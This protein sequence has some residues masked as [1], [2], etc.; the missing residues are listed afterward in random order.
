MIMARFNAVF[1]STPVLERTYKRSSIRKWNAGVRR[2][3]FCINISAVYVVVQPKRGL[4]TCIVFV[5][6]RA[7]YE[8]KITQN[9]LIM[10]AVL[11][12]YY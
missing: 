2:S 8:P 5:L 11:Y 4:L 3:A 7:F 12:S 1:A 10:P 6:S 9:Y